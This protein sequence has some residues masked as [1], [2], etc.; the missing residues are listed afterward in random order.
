MEK[1]ASERRKQHRKQNNK[2]RVENS[3]ELIKR[4]IEI[5]KDYYFCELSQKQFYLFNRIFI[6]FI[7]GKIC[8]LKNNGMDSKGT[9]Q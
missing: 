9:E 2:K 3:Y 7:I 1:C 6:K 4:S 5:V 8:V